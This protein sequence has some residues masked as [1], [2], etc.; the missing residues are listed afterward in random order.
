MELSA[1]VG[2]VLEGGGLRGVFTAGVLDF[3]MEN[4]L[5][6]SYVV[7]CSAG[8][9]NLLSFVAHQIGHTRDTMIQLDADDRYYGMNQLIK[10]QK[11]L[12]LD[13]VFYEYP[14]HQFPFD[15]NAFFRSPIESEMVVTNCET[16]KA[17]Y[18]SEHQNEK[19]LCTI[20]KASSSMPLL[21]KPVQL[22]GKEYLDGGIADAIPLRRAVETG[23]TKNIVVLTRQNGH[24]PHDTSSRKALYEAFYRDYPLLTAALQ[25][26]REM[27]LDEVAFVHQEEDAGRAFVIRPTLPEVSHLETNYD[28][29]MN[30][31]LHGYVTAQNNWPA[32][33]AFLRES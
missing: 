15:F 8:A 4:G 27:Y 1:P 3:W 28:V 13:K 18:L 31:Y 5:D 11:L 26:R 9:C 33:T 25:I 17:E 12:D 21:T 16:G 23:H 7:G 19:R 29:L 22:D 14:Y 24:A 10:H 32:L 2:L 20:T 6:V 30:Y